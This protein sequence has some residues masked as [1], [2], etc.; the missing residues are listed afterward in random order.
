M[1]VVKDILKAHEYFRSK[2]IKIDLVILNIPFD[3]ELQNV[4]IMN[5]VEK[6]YVF[7]MTKKYKEA[8]NVKI[9]EQA[10]ALLLPV[11]YL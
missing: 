7:A 11:L 1:Y 8:N 3:V 2:N 5:V 10:R 6:E 4:E 9:E